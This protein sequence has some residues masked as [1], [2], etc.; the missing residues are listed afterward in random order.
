MGFEHYSVMLHEC[1][2]GLDI[3]PGGTYVDA[4]AG[5]AG[6]SAEIAK[7]LTTGRLFA[8]DRDPDAVKVA[9]KRLSEFSCAE[10]IQSNFNSMKEELRNRGVES[11]DG[12]LLD[13]G[14]SSFQLDTAERGFSY[15][16]DAPLDMRMSKA[17]M[18]AA[19]LVNSAAL[20]ELTRIFREYGEEKFAY[21]IASRIV[22]EREK[23]KIETTFE[24][25][26]LIKASMPAKAK[27]DKNPS[28]RTFQALRI[29]VNGELDALSDGLN[30]AFD[31]LHSGGRLVAISFHSLEDR[32]IKQRF[33]SWCQGCTCPPD[34]PVCICGNTPK[35]KLVNKKLILPSERELKE[36]PRSESAKLR[37]LE[38]L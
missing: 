24:L 26:D 23:K 32:I 35:A 2:D 17:G 19:D 30:A 14:V 31:L 13:L 1:I 4:T 27:R 16:F 9:T 8:F 37:I 15:R 34:F 18:S 25:V 38:K 3:S 7:R 11:V 6:H 22:R 33:V 10:V 36:N 28:K 12:V 21:Q 5:G 29:A 20:E